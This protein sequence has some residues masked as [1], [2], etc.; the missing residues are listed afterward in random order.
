MLA[1]LMYQRQDCRAKVAREEL[2]GKIEKEETPTVAGEAWQ[3]KQVVAAY[4]DVSALTFHATT[5][6]TNLS[7]STCEFSDLCNDPK[8]WGAQERGRIR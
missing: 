8:S 1:A 5:N 2:L 4:A 7:S 3:G 6:P